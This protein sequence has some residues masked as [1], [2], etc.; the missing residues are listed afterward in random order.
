MS[1]FKSWLV[2][3][4]EACSAA[5]LQ[6]SPV[7]IR[8]LPP[9]SHSSRID[10]FPQEEQTLGG[11]LPEKEQEG[12]VEMGVLGRC[13]VQGHRLGKKARGSGGLSPLLVHVHCSL[14]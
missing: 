12:P 5:A 13:H 7:A 9:Q 3:P 14:V 8:G 4:K 2:A 10:H 1:L 6:C 11:H